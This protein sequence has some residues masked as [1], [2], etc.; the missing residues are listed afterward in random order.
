MLAH[1]HSMG[2]EYLNEQGG[3]EREGRSGSVARIR[4]QAQSLEEVRLMLERTARGEERGAE[5]APFDAGGEEGMPPE[6]LPYPQRATNIA[7]PAQRGYYD[8]ASLDVKAAS[9]RAR[10]A[11]APAGPRWQGEE[12]M[13]SAPYPSHVAAR[14]GR[15]VPAPD[16]EEALVLGSPAEEEP[17]VTAQA[18]TAVVATGEQETSIHIWLW[19]AA[20][21]TFGFGD[22]LTSILTFSTGGSEAN[23]AMGLV[24]STMG[25]SVMAFVLVKMVATVGVL[26]LSRLHARLDTVMATA[27]LAVGVFLV[28]FNAS[29]L[30]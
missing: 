21:L 2:N 26:L 30:L 22:T 17:K 11:Q 15:P 10:P 24:L 8:A 4:G 9:G 28:G 19:V 5:K 25:G 23:P 16:P 7:G 18:L 6:V 13:D 27:M 14:R 1:G 29:H 20:I 12:A 3:A